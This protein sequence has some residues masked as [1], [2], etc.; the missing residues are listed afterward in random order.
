MIRIQDQKIRKQNNFWCQ[1]VFHPT[2]AVEDPWGR[3]ILD[4]MSKDGAINTVRI[5]SMF[6]DIVY[7]DARGVKLFLRLTEIEHSRLGIKAL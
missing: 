5:Y 6:E 7:L 1:C 3:R 4:Q 2:D